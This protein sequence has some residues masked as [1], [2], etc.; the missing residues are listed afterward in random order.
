MLIAVAP[1][2]AR[3]SKQDHPALPITPVELAETA[4]ACLDAGAAML[5]LHVRDGCGRHTLDALTYQRAIEEITA[6]V[7][8]RVL[9]QITSEA[10]GIYSRE[11]QM[12]AVRR[13]APRCLSLALREILPDNSAQGTAGEFLR[14]LRDIGTLV[15]YILYSPR[16]VAW[17]EELCD[18]G[19]I[20][21]AAHFLLFVLGRFGG[22]SADSDDLLPYVSALRR[23][24]NW[25]ACAFGGNEHQVVQRAA[26]L[27]GHARVGFENNL[28]MPGGN[29]APDNAALVRVAA[30][31]AR[32][33]GRRIAT[34]S[35]ALGLF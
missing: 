16:E 25:M 27:G 7:G 10:A 2:G 26:A 29:T 22:K 17:Y 33:A 24:S 12:E 1:N 21:G 14:E 35:E 15:Q 28:L 8:E 3:R 31:A 9:I 11:E 4:A 6:T 13:L 5:H 19:V 23:K 32:A 18:R 34:N 20:P 30:E